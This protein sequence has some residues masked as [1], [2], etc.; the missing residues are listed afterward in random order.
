VQLTD[1]AVRDDAIACGT[2]SPVRKLAGLS[3][4]LFGRYW[5][6]VHGPLCARL[7]GLGYHVQTHFSR[8]RRANLWPVAGG[9]R[10]IEADFDG[11]VELG[12]ASDAEQSRFDAAAPLLYHQERELFAWS[13]AYRL[14]GGSR[15]YIDT[16]ADAACNGPDRLHRLHLYLQGRSAREF[17]AWISDWA[18]ELAQLDAVRK[19]RLHLPEPY[20]NRHPQPPSP[21]VDHLMPAILGQPAIMEIAFDNALAAGHFFHSKPYL[22][23]VPWQSAHIAAL[24]AFLVDAVHT[25]VHG[26]ELTM[27]G[28]RGSSAAALIADMGSVHQADPRVT[29]LFHQTRPA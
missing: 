16:Q 19:L 27:A 8:E 14:P 29:R 1:Y 7:P 24:A 12:F 20:D 6:D 15:T 28:L 25:Y 4:Q 22:A 23:T 26:G 17:R 13:G 21:G 18:A 10:R 5:R 2:Y 9:V 3:E 11:A